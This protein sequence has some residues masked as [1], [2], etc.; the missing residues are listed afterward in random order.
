MSAPQASAST[1][2]SNVFDLTFAPILTSEGVRFTGAYEAE[3]DI[4]WVFSIEG[5]HRSSSSR[6]R[7]MASSR[8]QA[9]IAY[10][11]RGTPREHRRHGAVA[12]TRRPDDLAAMAAF[13]LS[14]DASYINGQSILIDGGANF[15]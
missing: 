15:T 5:N 4:R 12:P 10:D 2:Y 11:D 9:A 6:V 1:F 3:H 8:R 13:L 7:V 14:D